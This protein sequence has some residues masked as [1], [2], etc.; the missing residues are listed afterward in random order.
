V[1]YQFV[2]AI[3][4]MGEACRKFDTPVTGGNVSFYNQSPDGPVYPTPTIGMVGLVE[5]LDKS[6]S[7][8]FKE[9]GDVIYLVG[10]S[11]NDINCSEY[12][13]KIHGVEFSPAPHF[14]LE[15]EYSLQQKITALIR[16]GAIVSAH[17]VSDGGVFVTL[18]ES[19]FYNDL[20]FSINT[21]ANIRKDAFLFGEAQSRVIVSVAPVNIAQFERLLQGFPHTKL[22]QVTDGQ[23]TIDGTD[24]GSIVEW[25]KLYDTAIE[26][27]LSR[28]LESEGALGML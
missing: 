10:T 17:D 18:C 19:G 4:G 24:W 11:R 25:K 14:D 5:D 3:K 8:N 26:R 12:L 15:E 16:E 2:N 9:E 22:G 20:G 27:M 7:L 13:H 28:E 23:V 21:D 6:M 1:Y